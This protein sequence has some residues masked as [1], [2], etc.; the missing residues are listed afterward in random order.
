MSKSP[1]FDHE[2]SAFAGCFYKTQGAQEFCWRFGQS[3]NSCVVVQACGV[4]Y[5]G[6]A[7]IFSQF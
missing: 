7:F 4:L 5:Y 3:E 2:W 1:W 6:F